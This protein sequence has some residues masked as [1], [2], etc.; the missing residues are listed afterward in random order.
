LDNKEYLKRNNEIIRIKDKGIEDLRREYTL[1]LYDFKVGQSLKVINK[2]GSFTF[3]TITKRGWCGPYT[4]GNSTAYPIPTYTGIE[5]TR[6]LVPRKDKAMCHVS[7]NGNKRL[8]L[9]KGVL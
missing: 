4:L 6:N 7:Q 5:L 2:G 1:E 9:L 3:M 8:E